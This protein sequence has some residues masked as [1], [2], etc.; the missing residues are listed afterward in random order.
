MPFF[1]AAARPY[2]MKFSALKYYR[3][4]F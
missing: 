1:C 3:L 2:L 4:P